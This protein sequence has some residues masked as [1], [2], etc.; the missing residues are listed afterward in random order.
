MRFSRIIFGAG[1]IMVL[2]LITQVKADKYADED[3]R[4]YPEGSWV[5]NDEE[6]LGEVLFSETSLSDPPGMGCVD[7]HHPDKAFADPEHGLPVSRGVITDRFGNRNDMMSAY[8]K[9]IPPLHYD[10]EE[11]VWVGG[12]FWDGRVN[13]LEEQ[14]MGPPFNPLEMAVTD[15]AYIA[16]RIRSLPYADDFR[17]V[18]GQ[19]ALDDDGQA[20]R[21]YA[22][23][24]AAFQRTEQFNRFDSKYDFY[25]QGKV[26]LTE[27]EKRGLELFVAEDKGNCAAC[28]PH[29]TAEDGTPPLFTDFTY[30]NLG[31]PPNP[32]LPFY[33]MDAALN[34]DGWQWKDRGLGQTLNDPALD[35]LFRVPSLR[36]VE[37]TPPYMHNGRLKTLFEV[38]AFYNTRDVGPWA[39]PEIPEGVNKEELGDLGLTNSEME[40]IVAFMLTL[41]DGYELEE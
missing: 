7:C 37:L 26:E 30:D 10:D 28:H 27:Q 39:P 24:L 11:E 17:K 2:V 19:D 6:Q 21:N 36:N 41:T 22:R 14:A 23:A 8:T 18:Y 9:F 25:L 29:L 4:T 31:L 32:E 16:D 40:D 3:N 1:A 33:T 34:P 20:F 35:G 38:V 15:T 5:L 13:T 12:L